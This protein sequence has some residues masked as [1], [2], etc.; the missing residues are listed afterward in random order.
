MSLLFD[1]FNA[2]TGTREKPAAHH[3]PTHCR[4]V[5][6]HMANRA[7]NHDQTFRVGLALVA[8]DTGLGISTVRKA[9]QELLE[10]GWLIDRGLH[11]PANRAVRA[12]QVRTDGEAWP[13]PALEQR[14]RETP[15][16]RRQRL[17][18]RA[19][20]GLAP[21]G[22][23]PSHGNPASHP[24]VT[25][26]R[27]GRQPGLAPDGDSPP[28]LPP[29]S[30]PNTPIVHAPARVGGGDP[31]RQRTIPFRPS[32][33]AEATPVPTSGTRPKRAPGEP[34]AGERYIAAFVAGLA[35]GGRRITPPRG[36][37][38]ALLG[39]TAATH[40]L[41][42]DGT[43]IVGEELIAWFRK[44]ARRFAQAVTR[45]EVHRGGISA[46]GL[47]TWLDN[48]APKQEPREDD[49]EADPDPMAP[50]PPRWEAPRPS[51]ENFRR[52]AYVPNAEDEA[53][54]EVQRRAM[55]RRAEAARA[56]EEASHG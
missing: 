47:Q 44:T 55:A 19:A 24:A 28:D 49:D 5:F 21:D 17:A 48:G 29:I 33:P 34:T 36:T 52:K 10:R 8:S 50:E 14:R 7:D 26:P 16:E 2:I 37:D 41:H 54:R 18:H 35:D 39:R 22:G 25:R 56:A 9:V 31:P 1:V 53:L 12:F 43:P 15:T 30:P 45:P 20:P 51:L 42:P 38:G 13:E 40:A 6:A 32:G 11:G 3:M 46:F 4:H 27:A 23:P